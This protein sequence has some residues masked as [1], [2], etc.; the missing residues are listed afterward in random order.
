[1]LIFPTGLSSKNKLLGTSFFSVNTSRYLK[2]KYP[3]KNSAPSKEEIPGVILR[4]SAR[5]EAAPNP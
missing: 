3:R 2:E 1:L 5:P 4:S